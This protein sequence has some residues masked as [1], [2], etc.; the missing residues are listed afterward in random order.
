MRSRSIGAPRVRATVIA[1]LLIALVLA[2]AGMTGCSL[3][4][5]GETKTTKTTPP[6]P[7][8]DSTSTADATDTAEPVDSATVIPGQVMPADN[9]EADSLMKSGARV[10]NVDTAAEYKQARVKGASNVPMS[11]LTERS[12]TWST[13]KTVLVT[14]RTEARSIS[15]AAYLAR[16]GFEDVHYLTSGHNGWNGKFEGA[17]APVRTI[18]SQVYYLYTSKVVPFVGDPGGV[19]FQEF[20]D[21][22]DDMEAIREEFGDVAF[23]FVDAVED[24]TEARRL[25]DRFNIPLLGATLIVPHWVVV[26]P[27]GNYRQLNTVPATNQTPRVFGFIYQ[28]QEIAESR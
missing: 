19:T 20:M 5:G 26:D 15:A 2:T 8:T 7:P 18:P 12:D 22:T 27:D 16:N 25:V 9:D 24:P 10:I 23:T 14:S 11:E 4:G 21:L 1:C 6:K 28:Q 13:S 3:L 17:D